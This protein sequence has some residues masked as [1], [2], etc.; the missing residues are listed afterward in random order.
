MLLLLTQLII[1]A[2]EYTRHGFGTRIFAKDNHTIMPISTTTF[3]RPL[4]TRSGNLRTDADIDA[5]PLTPTFMGRMVDTRTLILNHPAARPEYA[6][7]RGR[8]HRPDSPRW[9][10]F[11][12]TGAVMS[13]QI[14]EWHVG[15]LSHRRAH[16]PRSHTRFNLR[17]GE[18]DLS[19]HPGHPVL[20]PVRLRIRYAAERRRLNCPT[21]SPRRAPRPPF[22]AND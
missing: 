3:Q 19:H 20:P 10:S 1:I 9:R 21:S 4:P 11:P 15:T 2:F 16:Q 6:V 13:R 14:R 5:L 12:G 22:P 7:R 8:L 18:F 17:E